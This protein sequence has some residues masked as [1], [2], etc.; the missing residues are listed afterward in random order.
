[1]SFPKFGLLSV[2]LTKS[3]MTIGHAMTATISSGPTTAGRL[4]TYG[5][6]CAASGVLGT[7]VGVATIA[8]SHDVSTNQWSY[9]F[10][11]GM[12]WV[13]SIVLVLTHLLTATGFLGVLRAD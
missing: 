2:C 5:A 9:P 11:T 7:L 6:A 3:R 12:Q 10:S 8:W 13:I 4:R 1:M